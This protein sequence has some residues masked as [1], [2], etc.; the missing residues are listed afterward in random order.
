MMR[1]LQRTFAARIGRLCWLVGII[2]GRSGDPH[3]RLKCAN[4][5]IF[6]KIICNQVTYRGRKYDVCTK[7]Q[8]FVSYFTLI[9]DGL[10]K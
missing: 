4:D 2:E 7:C 8:E 5:R 9:P 1:Q 6:E 10:C 3:I